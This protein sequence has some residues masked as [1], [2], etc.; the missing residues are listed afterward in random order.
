MFCR[1]YKNLKYKELN[2]DINRTIEFFK[3]NNLSY[4]PFFFN[5]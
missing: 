3:K 4:W 5:N 2:I 1:E